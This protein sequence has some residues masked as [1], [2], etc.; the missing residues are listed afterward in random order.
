M[1]RIFIITISILTISFSVFADLCRESESF[2]YD[3][4]RGWFYGEYCEPKKEKPVTKEKK[5]ELNIAVKQLE[6]VMED[7]KT[8]PEL[9]FLP[10]KKVKI[11]WDILDQLDPD[12][13]SEIEKR[14]RKIAIMHP[15]Y[16]NVREYMHLQKYMTE[17]SWAYSETFQVVTQTDPVL[18]STGGSIESSKFARD[19][20]F[21]VQ[22]REQDKKLKNYAQDK[23]GLVMFYKD[24]C[25]YCIEEKRM[26]DSLKDEY[27]FQYELVN[28]ERNPALV[29]KFQV[30]TVPDMFIVFR[31]NN[32]K[33]VWRRLGIGLHTLP[34]LKEI[35][36]FSIQG[37]ESGGG[38]IN[39]TASLY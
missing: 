37:Y 30:S 36:Y 1:V 17:K 23:A 29:K 22:N 8:E 20:M 31:D 10:D 16:E 28:I 27:G 35:I 34:E 3:G 6:N 24:G 26:F 14:S 13:I 12:S 18:A 25:P 39:G 21:S 5:K 33:P 19:M 7:K 38:Y 15:T 32:N 4:H 9:K 2:F 11:P